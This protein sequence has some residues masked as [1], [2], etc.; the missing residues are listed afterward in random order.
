MFFYGLIYPGVEKRLRDFLE[1]LQTEM[2]DRRRLLIFLNTTGGSA[3]TV[4]TLVEIIRYNYQEVWFVVPDFALSA[5]T[6]FCMSGD[7]IWM[8]YSSSLGP[9]DPQVPTGRGDWVPA[10]AAR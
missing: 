2:P 1:R 8:D 3:E 7:K 6:I 5:G 9:I 10:L 4:E